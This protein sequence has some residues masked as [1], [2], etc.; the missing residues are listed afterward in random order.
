[1]D[2]PKH[3]SKE[4][5]VADYYRQSRD[6]FLSQVLTDYPN[7][8]EFDLSLR[9]SIS[10]SAKNGVIIYAIL[11]EM[12]EDLY[13]LEKNNV[14]INP[15]YSQLGKC[16]QAIVDIYVV[17]KSWKS[18]TLLCNGSELDNTKLFYLVD[19]CQE[20]KILGHI[21]KSSIDELRNEY[22][23]KPHKKQQST[24]RSTD[25]V[26]APIQL[27]RNNPTEALNSVI[28]RYV[29]LFGRN[30]DVQYYSV[31]RGGTVVVI[32]DNLIVYFWLSPRYWAALHSPDHRDWEYPYIMIQELTHND[33]FKFNHA[34]FKRN[35]VYDYIGIDF[36]A[37]HGLGYYRKEIDKFKLV[38]KAF[39]ELK[40]QERF[41]RYPGEIHHFI[42]LR[43]EG[44][45]GKAYYGVGDT[46]Q[47]VHSFI[48][49]LCAQLESP[50]GAKSL[51]YQEN[52][53]FLL[54]F[55]SWKGKPKRWRL[56]NKFS[57]SHVDYYIKN[58]SDLFSLPSKIV[59]DAKKGMYDDLEYGTYTKPSNKWK[60]EELVYNT[61]KK[62]YKDYQVIYQYSPFYLATEKGCMSYDV[63]I[64]GLKVAIEYQG[65][66]HFEP[67]DYFGGRESFEKQQERDKLKAQ[68]SIENGITLIYI[69][70][71]EDITPAL[72]RERIENTIVEHN[73]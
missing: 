2:K 51:S 21:R 4:Y 20:K 31:P 14:T 23:S 11:N 62:L 52:N 72:I 29:E 13:T 64:C 61:V 55:H 54:A 47:N 57:Y 66:Q 36:Y 65:K 7:A 9:C 34:A 69:N 49:K 73:K 67:V 32:E 30:K 44:A 16:M 45:D 25:V 37:F 43:M 63:Y 53:D 5:P 56:E 59:L 10:S 22:I 46:K 6:A 41:D 1:M 26:F 15:E 18:T 50:Q 17:C 48:L 3:I 35:F 12:P 33:L 39:P 68:K 28:C 70:Y 38:N 58:D 27:S 42:I 60:S 71:W 40:L 24:K 8:H 19:F